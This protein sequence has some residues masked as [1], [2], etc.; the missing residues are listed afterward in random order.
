MKQ[1]MHRNFTRL[2]KWCTWFIGRDLSKIMPKSA[3]NGEDGDLSGHQKEQLCKERHTRG[4]L[5]NFFRGRGQQRFFVLLSINICKNKTYEVFCLQ[6]TI[7]IVNKAILI[8]GG[9]ATLT[10]DCSKDRIAPWWRPT[11]SKILH[12]VHLV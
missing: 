1:V 6:K 11:A 3:A 4:H 9:H 10:F 12:S 7:F 5:K 2:Q 8:P